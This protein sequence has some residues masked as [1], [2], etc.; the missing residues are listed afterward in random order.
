MAAP[1]GSFLILAAMVV[2]YVAAV[3][4]VKRWFY[5]RCAATEARRDSFA[6]LA[7]VEAQV[8]SSLDLLP[9]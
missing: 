4:I 6:S 2:V 5:G 1:A 3:E 7:F 8:H 9:E